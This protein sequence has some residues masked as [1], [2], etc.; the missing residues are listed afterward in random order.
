MITARKTENDGRQWY[1]VV[2]HEDGYGQDAG[3]YEYGITQDGALIDSEGFPVEGNEYRYRAIM[4]ACE[5]A[6]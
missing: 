4:M 2:F 3:T 1:E 6:K 5:R